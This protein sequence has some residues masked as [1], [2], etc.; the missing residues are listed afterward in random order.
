[1]AIFIK[2]ERLDCQIRFRI[3]V[4][5]SFICK[6]L[7]STEAVPTGIDRQIFARVLMF[8]NMVLSIWFLL[9]TAST[10]FHFGCLDK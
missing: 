5:I 10:K 1:M 8:G 3:L 7:L 4:F 6:K 9:S 2:E